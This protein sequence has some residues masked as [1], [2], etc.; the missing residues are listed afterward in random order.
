[1]AGGSGTL[2]RI[3]H[4]SLPRDQ[5]FQSYSNPVLVSLLCGLWFA[6]CDDET[7]GVNA[8]RRVC[9]VLVPVHQNGIMHI[10]LRTNPVRLYLC[11]GLKVLR[12][13]NGQKVNVSSSII[14]CTA[15]MYWK[16]PDV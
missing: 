11:F 1:M 9:L 8:E 4:N 14:H 2:P 7:G 13:G 10:Q 6:V 3:L 12:V 16:E 15:S 5:L